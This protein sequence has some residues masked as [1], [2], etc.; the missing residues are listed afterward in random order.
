M[1]DN[2]FKN[3]SPLKGGNYWQNFVP[4]QN[5]ESKKTSIGVDDYFS[6][7]T[8]PINFSRSLYDL[9]GLKFDIS[10]SD[11]G[12][13]LLQKGKFDIPIGKDH[14]VYGRYNRRRGGDS[15]IKFSDYDWK[16]GVRF[17]INTK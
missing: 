4:N 1:P 11:I 8:K 15:P 9:L 14:S 10:S 6:N 17:P 2:R 5:I 13:R 12:V 3:S 16:V 7:L